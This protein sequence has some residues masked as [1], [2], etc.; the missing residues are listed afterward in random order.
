M[1]TKNQMTVGELMSILNGLTKYGNL[2]LDTP[3]FMS[4]D[5]E[6]N[7]VHACFGL[8]IASKNAFFNEGLYEYEHEKGVILL[9]FIS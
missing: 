8:D 7:G 9:W 2:P 6:L 4:D 3:I 1:Y 5:N